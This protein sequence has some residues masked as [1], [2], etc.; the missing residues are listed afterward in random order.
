[1]NGVRFMVL[2]VTT[3]CN[4]ACG[5]CHTAAGPGGRDMAPETAWRALEVLADGP[6]KCTVELAGGE[7]LLNW[8]LVR[9]LAL[10]VDPARVRLALQTN[11]LLLNRENLALLR[12]RRVGLGL[13]LDGPPEINDRLR[14]EGAR[15]LRALDLIGK[16]GLGVNVT[17]VLTRGNLAALPR[18]LLL[19][20]QKP[21]VRVVNLDLVRALGRATP[22]LAPEPA[23]LRNMVPRLLDSLAFVNARRWPPLK[24]REV[25]QTLR[26]ARQGRTGP[27]CLAGV[28]GY[29]A[30][31][32]GGRIA[33]CSSLTTEPALG[34][35]H[36]RAPRLTG[37]ASLARASGLPPECRDC[38]ALPACRGGCPARRWAAEGEPT[39]NPG[40]CALRG[41][42]WERLVA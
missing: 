32:P 14:G 39:V 11:G 42:L 30:V 26:R 22:G 25:E 18:F 29:A 27:Y 2:M 19:L 15:V 33:A 10:K 20:A 41:T 6:G 40:E 38:P 23:A 1:M 16:A 35:G 31:T 5:Y 37:L 12:R 3:R 4:L 9:E 28:G 17:V 36:V 21:A 13:S 24:V 8:P 34:A 7:P